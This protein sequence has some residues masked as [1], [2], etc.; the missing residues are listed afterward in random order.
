P[1]VG[2]SA[3]FN[4]M[5]GERRAIVEDQPGTT[6][7]RLY[8]EA[9]WIGVPF[10]IIDTGG[11]Q[12][13]DEYDR[14]TAR[15]ISVRTQ[16]QAQLAIEEAD[17]IL[18]LV[19]GKTGVSAADHDV[20]EVLRESGK[21]VVLGVNKAESQERRDNAI[22]FYELGL[23]EPFSFSALHGIG[24][25]D[26]L[27]EVVRHLP[28]G[29]GDEAEVELPSFAV[30]GR[31]NVGKSS[32]LN[33]L[34]GRERSI[35]SEMPGTTRDTI[36]TVVDW[37]GNR[38][39]LIDTAGIRR[40]GRIEPGVEKHS[41]LRAERAIDR[42]DVALVVLDAEE[43]FTAQDQHIAGYVTEAQKGIVFVVNK[44]DLV[45]KDERTMNVFK[46]EAAEF[47]QFAP[48]API[49]FVSALTGQRVDQI[50]DM[51]LH[52]YG[53]RQKRITTG[54]LNRLLRDAT[55]RHPP[56]ARPSSWLKFYYATQ[57]D[58]APPRFVFFCN[59]PRNVHFSYERY[60]E[61]E[62]REHYRFDGTPIVLHFRGRRAND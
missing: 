46:A 49:I 23:G 4:R 62:I 9:D 6:R 27:D 13:E 36:D 12:E 34:I 7:D 44:W 61:N 53:E 47:F 11:L 33:A 60:L 37:A 14:L 51:A 1:N 56:P 40:R 25:G 54:E 57:S 3:L 16:N 15:E 5:T 21:P 32:L 55:A 22:E 24:T 8:G 20:A 41:V 38:V 28:R 59:D 45:E 52:V 29:E 42:A 48:W 43:G 18:F 17:V 19:D 26:V 30:V 58:V 39:L 50:I 35:V 31:P 2:K 10:T